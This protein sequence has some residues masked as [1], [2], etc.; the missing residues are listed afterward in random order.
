MFYAGNG[1]STTQYG[2]GVAVADALSGPYHKMDKP[3]LQATDRWAA[4]GHPSVT[5]NP[6]G[7]PLMFLHATLRAGYKQFR[8]L[9]SITLSFVNG[10][11]TWE[12]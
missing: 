1:I 8:A 9:L 4:P 7:K 11:V 5:R 10:K 3:F 2:I 6:D 12:K